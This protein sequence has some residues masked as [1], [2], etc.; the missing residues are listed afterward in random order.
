MKIKSFFIVCLALVA[1]I[2]FVLWLAHDDPDG[3]PLVCEQLSPGVE[4]AKRCNPA[5][6]NRVRDSHHW[7]IEHAPALSTVALA[8]VSSFIEDTGR[9][10]R[11][12]F[13][14]MLRRG[15]IVGACEQMLAHV[16]RRGEPDPERV[17]RREYERAMC[18][19][20]G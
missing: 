16:N 2:A 6:L 20:K 12:R 10:K 17:K 4:Y 19:S 11:T 18:L 8:G 3:K 7:V 14:S 9:R 13:Y 15:D 1:G 5:E